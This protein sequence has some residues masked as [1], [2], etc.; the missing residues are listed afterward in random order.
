MIP[1]HPVK[2]LP[3]RIHRKNRCGNPLPAS[4]K[5]RGIT[6]SSAN[7]QRPIGRHLEIGTSHLAKGGHSG[8][9]PGTP[10]PTIYKW[11][12]QLDD[13]QSLHRK[14]LFHQTSIY[15]WLFGVP[16][17]CEVGS[18]NPTLMLQWDPSASC[19]FWSGF[20]RYLNTGY[21][22]DIW[23]TRAKSV[24]PITSQFCLAEPC[25]A[26]AFPRIWGIMFI[27]FFFWLPS[28]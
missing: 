7:D 20:G 8:C 2:C 10:R 24:K 9:P 6:G 4:Q 11:L 26:S 3:L 22:Q 14:W 12:F 21:S 28:F 16:G 13:S 1:S 19:F 25:L 18:V 15:K 23:S 27:G 17:S 5:P